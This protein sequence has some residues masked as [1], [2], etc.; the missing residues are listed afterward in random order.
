MS[1]TWTQDDIERFMRFVDKLPSGCWF[2]TGARSRGGEVK[3]QKLYGSFRVNGKTVRAHRFACEAIAG[4]RCP[5]G[6]HRDHTC[7]FTLCV[8]PDHMEIVTKEENERRKQERRRSDARRNG[9]DRKATGNLRR[10][11]AKARVVVARGAESGD[12]GGA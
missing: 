9:R 6:H 11:R 12:A 1:L 4:K 2:W 7:R 5:Q 3:K 8:N 10:P